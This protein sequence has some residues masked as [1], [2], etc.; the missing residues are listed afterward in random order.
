MKKRITKSALSLI[1]V[2]AMMMSMLSVGIVTA[3]SAEVDEA[4]T[5]VLGTVT[6]YFKNNLG[7]NNVYM[8]FYSDAM[9]SDPNPWIGNGVSP[10]T[11]QTVQMTYDASV[12]A[13]AYKIDHLHYSKYISFAK[14][15]QSSYDNYWQTDVV[16]RADFAGTAAPFFTPDA[17]RVERVNDCNYYYYGE[18][19]SVPSVAPATEAP[20]E[21][22]TYT[23]KIWNKKHTKTDDYDITSG[24]IDPLPMKAADNDYFVVKTVGDTETTVLEG[25][26][27]LAEK[28]DYKCTFDPSVPSIKFTKKQY[29]RVAISDATGGHWIG[30]DDAQVFVYTGGAY[31]AMS[32]SID[33]NSGRNVWYLDIVQPEDGEE[34]AFLRAAATAKKK[35]MNVDDA[36][37]YFNK[38][39]VAFADGA[40]VYKITGDGAIAAQPEQINIP[41]NTVTNFGYGIWVDPTGDADVTNFVKIYADDFTAEDNQFWLYLPSNSDKTNL[42]F[43]TNFSYLKIGENEIA[44]GE[45]VVLNVGKDTTSLPVSYKRYDN[46]GT[47]TATLHFRKTAGTAAMFMNTAVE[48]YT[49]VTTEYA[50]NYTEYKDTVSTKGTYLLY[51]EDGNVVNTDTTLKKIKGR[52]NSSWEASVC[53]YGKYAYNVT[54]TEAAQLID[55]CEAATKY[56]LLANNVD[57]SMLR[58]TVIY[59]IGDAVGMPYTPNVRLVDV[60]DNGKYLGAYTLAEKVEY[61]AG[62]LIPD[63]VSADEMNDSILCANK[64]AKSGDLVEATYTA[65]S[66]TVYTYQ[67]SATAEGSENPYEYDGST[68]TIG[69]GEDAV[70]YTLDEEFMKSANFLLEH[71]IASRYKAE[72]TWFVSGRTKQAV[73]PKYPEFATQKQVQWMIE[74]YDALETAAYAKNFSAVSAV[75]DAESFAK[76]YLIQELAM[77]LDAGATSY[78][79]LGGGSLDKLVAAPLW[80]Y[81]WSVG[82]YGLNKPVTTGSGAVCP[83]DPT[84]DFANVKSV[85]SGFDE[86]RDQSMLNLQAQLTK[87]GEFWQLCQKAWTTEIK[88]ALDEYLGADGKI[89]SELL[90]AYKASAEMNESRWGFMEHA[91]SSSDDNGWGVV[92]TNHYKPGSYE[93]HPGNPA[94]YGADS[95][96][97]TNA[98]YYLNDW[99]TKRAE[100]MSNTMTLYD[101]SLI[102]QP[103]EGPTEAPA[104]TVYYLVGTM[105]SWTASA[106]YTLEAHESNDG[107]EEYKL[108]IDLKAGD[109]FKVLSSTDKWFPSGDNY[110]VAEDGTYAVYFRPNYDGH[111]DWHGKCIYAAKQTVVE[112]TDAPA[113]AAPATEAPATEAPATEAPV[114]PTKTIDVAVISYLMTETQGENLYVHYWGGASSGDALLSNEFFVQ[115]YKSLGSAYWNN[116][117]QMFIVL[118]AQ[119]P[120]D[121]TGFKVCYKGDPERWFGDDADATK[122]DKAW[123]FNYDG[124]KAFYTSTGTVPEPT[125]A[126]ATEAP[127]T[128]APA[129]A[130]PATVYYLVGSFNQWTA[131]ADYALAAHESNDGAEEYKIVID[132]KSGDQLKV[133]SSADKWYPDSMGNYEITEDGTYA[134]YFRPNKDGHDD[135]YDKYIYAA[136]QAPATVDEP[137][138]A[139]AEET[140]YTLKIW[141]KKHTKTDDYDITS[142]VIDP[143]PMKAADNDYFVVKTVGDTETTVLEGSYPLAEKADYKCTFDPSVPSIKFTK[144]QYCRVA[145]S[146]ATGGHWIGNDDAQVFVY[147]GGAYTAMSR[148]I[149]TNSGRNVW[150]LDIV[151]P[152]D[153]EEIAFLR[154]AATA[155]KKNMNVDDASTYFNKWTVAFADGANVYKITGDGAIA[156]QPEQINIPDNTV[157]NFGYGI[158]VDPTGD[159]DVT[160]FV[161]IYA[162]DFTAEDNQFWLYLPSNSDKTNLTFYTNF[163]YLKIGENEIAKGEPVVL[164]VGKDTTSLPVSYKRYDNGGTHTA[165]LHFRKTAGTAAMFMNTAVELYTGVTTEYAQNY[166]EYKDTVSTKGTYLLY[167]EDGNVVNTDTTLKKIKG[168]GN[169]SWEASVCLYGK[170]AYNVTITEAAQ[171]I[172]G[173]EAATKYCLLANNVDDSMLRNT[174]IYGIGDAVGMPYTPNVR[175]VDVYD[176]GKYLGAYTLAEKVEYGAGTLIPDAVSADEMNDSILCANKR[177]KSGDLVEA[178]YTAKSGTVYTYQYSATA[179][180]SEN[181]YEYDG[182]TVT[183]GEGEDAVTYT[184]DEE[185]MKSANFL[186][187]H[188]I[189]S[190][191]KAEAT[192]FVSGRTKQAVVPKYPEFATQKQV[193]WMIEEYDALET[194]AYAKNFSAVSAVAD[195]ES[196]AKVY[197]I[198][199]LAMNLDAGATSYYILGGGSLDKLVAAPLWDYDWSVGCYGLNKPVTTGSGAVCPADPTSDFANV[200][201]VK[202][203][204]DEDRDQSMLNL[205]AQLTKTGE[206]WQL[207]QK[208]WTT[209]IKL[210]LDEYLGADG[211]ILSELLPAYKASAEMNESRWGFM[212][213]AY[214][215]SDDNGWGVVSTNHYKPGSYEFHPGNPA[216]YGADSGSYTNAVYYLN[217]WLTKR[218][219]YM[220]NTMTLYDP[221]LIEQ[222]TEGPTEAP[223]P[224]VYY[225][226]GTMN[227]WTASADYT[228]EAHES[229]DGKEEYKLVIDL[230]AGDQFKVLS[231]TDKWFPS[232]DN[233]AVAEDGTYAVYFRPNYD[234]HDDWH[235]KCIYAAKQTVVE[236]T[237]A[238]ATAAP[239][240][241]APATEAPVDGRI[242]FKP[243]T[244]W[245][246][247][248]AKFAVKVMGW[249]YWTEKWFDLE[250]IGDGIYAA[251]LTNTASWVSCTFSRVSPSTGDIWNTS[252][253]FGFQ[254]N[255]LYVLYEDQWDGADGTYAPYDPD[256][257][258][259]PATEAPA[260]EAPAT[261]APATVYYLV[262]SFNHWTAADEYAFTAHESADG[263]EE[264][265]IV[266]DLKAGDQLKV[267]SS[268]GKWYPDNMGN[269]EIKEDGTYAIYFRPNK[270]GHDDWYGKYIYAALQTPA[271]QDEPTE[272]PATEA[273]ATEAPATEAPA[274]EAPATEAPATVYYLVG[275]FNHWTASAEYA[276][277]AHESNDGAEEYKI[278]VDLKAGDQLKVTSSEGKWYPDNMGNY[279]ITEDGTY[280]IYFRPNKDGH[281]DWYAKYIYAAL[282]APATVDEPTEAPATEA[283]ATEA[284]ATEAPATEAPATVYYL[285]GNFN[286]WTVADE[287]ALTAIES[288]DGAEE[289]K[290]V[291]DFNKGDEFKVKSSDGKWFPDNADNYKVTE[292]GTYNVY[293]RPNKDGHDDWYKKVIYAS[294]QAPATVDEPTEAPAT[295]APATEAPATEAPATEAPATEAPATEAPATVYYLVGSFNQWTAADEYALAAHESADGAEE[296]KI[297][298]DLKAG[299]QLKVTSSEGKWYPDN[300]GNYEIKEDGTYAIYFRPN[301]DG[302]DDWYGKYIYAALQTPATQDEPT[303]APATEAPA[304]EAPATEAPVVLS[305]ILGDIN[306]NGEIDILDATMIQRY[307]VGLE[308]G[309]FNEA[310]ADVTGDGS[311][312][313]LD[314]TAIQR[315]LAGYT[316]IYGI[317]SKIG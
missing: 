239:A 127:A 247:D 259:A 87:T 81:D 262:G 287:Y 90:P 14:D 92:S 71:E 233:Y 243:S 175:L 310:V 292:A 276:F 58:N 22:A 131:S 159:A 6:V 40:N 240:T 279:E 91:Y 77:N 171:L 256:A 100:Y 88:L 11:G 288:A 211:K 282:Q 281:D 78:Y 226:V 289:Y 126:P 102:E 34:I 209:E 51:D 200:K 293:F 28:A 212:E 261:E 195:A 147:T 306:N 35:N 219:E 271:T 188:E 273:P 20:A 166:T 283:P 111:D 143:L 120:A 5:A 54:I 41:D 141:N 3:S 297:V 313:I 122:Y 164:N 10:K 260:T 108:V 93:F 158:W 177:A 80:D 286:S 303:E 101:P 249:K 82:C 53:L 46:G 305:D 224:T 146:D 192:W 130:A 8:T 269:Y 83:A 70:T 97:Y 107:K 190:R 39:T 94:V 302:H 137:T 66:G 69:E 201:S 154:A 162:D 13:Y 121:S 110:A 52:G 255:A 124:D 26:Y 214:S 246:N 68:V 309:F 128:E 149:D 105:N 165:T 187:E 17:T 169:S 27:P 24:V 32:R 223:A 153:G 73:V 43:Y 196:F 113:T 204:F 7:W 198:Q 317:G 31:T 272:A 155:K 225:L 298:I 264:Y 44:K 4:D 263:A 222:P 203:G 312:S 114:V 84:S 205:Q 63:A 294:L 178:T 64:R 33:T 30:N 274:T 235:G 197:L 18:W 238:P 142:G 118:K 193:Q 275:S 86:D 280:A 99:L 265:K 253:E 37:T 103:T 277:A 96:S 115:E 138:E 9:N 199:E 132:L 180:G 215:S 62:T 157:T 314:A 156:A 311:V 244:N 119:I 185:F 61:G 21:E 183:I 251:D 257:T 59:G 284:P 2:L 186:L 152:E 176:N 232:G 129:T 299:D 116:Q 65:K 76:V 270:D 139:P 67:Y 182:S 117:Q 151:Q 42:T 150:Y 208:A 308:T 48:L 268:E 23:L 49:G 168:R 12:D 74:E 29:C 258:E 221:S 207:C 291:V 174:V 290:I 230:K 296:Y 15:N 206:F 163:S 112:P 295:E 50:Q 148:S 301:K 89:L 1:L 179:E 245:C 60:Y 125:D 144:K 145:I 75:A 227:S 95:G 217:D 19:S 316:D 109:Q 140:T 57:D 194:A 300:M 241:E 236:P 220:S 55:G 184:L 181:P 104:P 72:A 45:P 307:L 106:D 25:S 229:N 213:H 231:S 267:T 285:V 135:W 56:C 98:V 189:A 278:V 172:D 304:T 242:Y 134:I 38:W 228:L 248:N 167:D 266:I 191:Y 36:S 254:N 173:C 237:D 315:Y 47:H 218:A 170:Y 123:I 85:K 234:G 133:K 160:N 136:L 161:K 16:Y 216:V 252:K 202:S 79:I 210:A 250:P